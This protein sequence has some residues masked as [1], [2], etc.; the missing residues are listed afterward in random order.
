MPQRTTRQPYDTTCRQA[1]LTPERAA[2]ASRHLR[3]QLQNS[4]CRL[5]DNRVPLHI[6]AMPSQ[7][8]ACGDGHFHLAPELFL[9]VDGWTRFDFPHASITLNEGEALLVPPKLLHLE[10]IGPSASGRPFRNIVINA[11]D[12]RLRCSLAHEV[13]PGIPGTYHLESAFHPHV[14]RIGNWLSDASALP[15]RSPVTANDPLAMRQARSLVI[16]ATAGVLQSLDELSDSRQLPAEP[17]LVS[18]VHLLV[19]NEL[20]DRMLSVRRL[21]AALD[22]TADYLSNLFS[23]STG[24]HLSAFI[25]RQRIERA[26]HLLRDSD[27]SSKEIAWACGYATHSYFIRVFRERVGVTP[28]AWRESNKADHDN[29]GSTNHAAAVTS[30]VTPNGVTACTDR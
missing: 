24:E 3:E 19:Q 1:F 28:K 18:R 11:E 4:L 15:N 14:R 6:Q 8:V 23:T 22:C 17:A 29:P 16:A 26:A 7:W 21:A 25:N 30:P 10:H 9:Q 5:D 12:N 20:G 27:L 13:E 2:E